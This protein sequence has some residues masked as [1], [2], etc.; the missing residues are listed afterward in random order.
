MNGN[1]DVL[2]F[3]PPFALTRLPF[4]GDTTTEWVKDHSD[5]NFCTLLKCSLAI[6][7]I[8]C[9]PEL[10][11][12]LDD[13]FFHVWGARKGRG[14]F[15]A[16]ASLRWLEYSTTGPP[17]LSHSVVVGHCGPKVLESFVIV[18]LKEPQALISVWMST[19]NESQSSFPQLLLFTYKES[20]HA[21]LLNILLK[22]IC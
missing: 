22:W 3:F 6:T 15:I 10:K 14:F 11:I 7:W 13:D 18:V 16:T 1:D 5:W 17:G 20:Y 21:Y 4:L 2:L 12:V 9:P 8:H 19:Q